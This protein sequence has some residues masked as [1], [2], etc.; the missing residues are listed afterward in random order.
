MIDASLVDQFPILSQT[1]NGQPLVY[2]D[3]AATTQK[4]AVVI[5][6]MVDYYERLNANV[7]RG[8]HHLSQLSTDAFELTRSKLQSHLHAAHVHEIIFTKGTTDSI[9]LVA[10]GYRSLLKPGDEILVSEMAHHSNLVPWQITAELTGATLKIIPMTAEDELDVSAYEALL[11]AQTKLVA[12]NHISNA[13]GT[14]NPVKRLTD[15]AHAQGAAVLVDGAQAL[16][17]MMV[18]VQALGVDFYAA[19]AHKMYGPTGIGLLYGTTDWLNALPPYQGGGE[20]IAE[21]SATSSTYA[22]LPHKFEAGTPNIEAVIAW[23]TAIDWMNA[24]GLA[25]IEAHETQ[26]LAYG[27]QLLAEIPGLI[28]HGSPRHKAAVLSFSI[29]GLHPYDVGTLLDQMGIAV[30]TGHH[31]AQPIMARLQVPGTIRASLA[32]YTR[33]S[34][35]EALASGLKRAINALT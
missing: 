24:V 25:N 17:H 33:R 14:I 16:P 13:L 29:D 35:L 1:V 8:V 10:H 11:S 18:D 21:V 23:G 2:L 6:A 15:M 4:P 5:A 26:L 34:D 7:H 28:R 31:C 3:N 30:R 20:M 27:H 22:D 12:F 32:A 19:S 9:N